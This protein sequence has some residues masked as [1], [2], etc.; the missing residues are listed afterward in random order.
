M[1]IDTRVIVDVLA[2]LAIHASVHGESARAFAEQI[3]SEPL[4]APFIAL[5]GTT[6]YFALREE[7]EGIARRP[8][9]ALA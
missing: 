5:L 6:T 4:S 2:L 1:R 8:I 9:P 3:V 7:R